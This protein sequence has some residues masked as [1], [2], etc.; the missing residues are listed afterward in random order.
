M[1][2][3]VFICHASEDKEAF[4]RPLV[5]E[6]LRQKPGLQIWYDE[7][8]LVLG[9]S[10]RQKIDHGLANSKFGVVVFSRNFFKKKWPQ[11]ELNG[12]VARE[13]LG[14]KI[15][16]PVWHNI[17]RDE[18]VHYSPLI[19]DRLAVTSGVG[20][21]IVASKILSTIEE[22]KEIR[23]AA[24]KGKNLRSRLILAVIVLALS[25]IGVISWRVMPRVDLG[26]RKSPLT[27]K[28]SQERESKKEPSEES[29][30]GR[31][32]IISGLSPQEDLSESRKSEPNTPVTL[33]LPSSPD[34][35]ARK[36]PPTCIDIEVMLKDG[37]VLKGVKLECGPR[38][39][40]V[41]VYSAPNL[42]FTEN[43]GD[44]LEGKFPERILDFDRLKK[45]EFEDLDQSETEAAEAYYKTRSDFYKRK[46]RAARVRFYDGHILE[47][48][49]IYD[50]CSFDSVY[51]KGSLFALNPQAIIFK[52]RSDCQGETGKQAG[53]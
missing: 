32:R 25:L 44:M 51:E 23:E 18:I 3:D 8:S 28:G 26:Q 14:K 48:I 4:V 33:P 27:I 53:S 31:S 47:R 52:S 43:V 19:A 11:Q 22:V 1:S 12:L 30:R 49:Y 37:G 46:W 5:A 41:I 38:D 2:W 34:S 40:H 6:L 45:I 21:E 29:P 10:L 17:S 16:L 7:F 13:E 35:G 15:I 20:L 42:R 36:N 24:P 9:D 50:N 39:A